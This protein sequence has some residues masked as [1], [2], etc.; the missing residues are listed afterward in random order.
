MQGDG[1]VN[2]SGRLDVS[3]WAEGSAPALTLGFTTGQVGDLPHGG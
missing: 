2:L 1:E 3:C